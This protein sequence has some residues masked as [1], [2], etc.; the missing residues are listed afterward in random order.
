MRSESEVFAQFADKIEARGDFLALLFAIPHIQPT[1]VDDYIDRAVSLMSCGTKDVDELG[2]AYAIREDGTMSHH[3]R[4]VGLHFEGGHVLSKLRVTNR[5]M[6][7]FDDGAAPDPVER[8]AQALAEGDQSAL[9]R[10]I[11]LTANPDLPTYDPQ[12]AVEYFVTAVRRGEE[13]DLAPLAE[14][15]R[16]TPEELR[17]ALDAKIDWDQILQRVAHNGDVTAAYALGMRMRDSA[18]ST[19][20]LAQ[21]LDWLET[22]AQ[23]GHRD[24]MYETGY[25]LGFGLGRAADAKGAVAWLE[26]AA[27][28]GHPDAEALAHTLRIAGGL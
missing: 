25:A 14:I 24:A 19:S 23:R 13:T 18:T 11:R 7:W 26:Q 21:S 4:N 20:S 15:Y 10:L 3:W 28:L 6:Q 2:D 8:A 12:S 27:S 5:Q 16:V 22:A 1:Q 17:T 9:M